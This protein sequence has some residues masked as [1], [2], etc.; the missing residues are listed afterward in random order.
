MSKA[1]IGDYYPWTAAA[2]DGMALREERP[3][4]LD[5]STE[6]P[7]E[8]IAALRPDLVVATTYRDL[9]RFTD[10]LEAF[11]DV[12]GPETTV[13]EE[14]W[15]Q[16]MLR[17]GDLVGRAA[18][19]Q[20]LVDE[21]EAGIAEIRDAHPEW[22][23][24]TYVSGPVFPN[25]LYVLN[26]AGD[27]SNAIYEAMGLTLSPGAE[28]LPDATGSPGRALVSPEQL[29]VLEADVLMLVHYGGDAA[30]EQS[31]PSRCSKVW[32]SS[33]AAPTSPSRTWSASAWPTPRC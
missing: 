31:G 5:T 7:I 6:L 24:K 1:F 23:G 13:A 30:Q 32:T 2:L 22:D 14:S 25:E 28:D 29:E 21:V 3:E 18:Q 33:S 12:L 17:V 20:D 16:T 19:A 27:L 9:E 10:E 15:Q 4:L 26:N 8:A 11:A